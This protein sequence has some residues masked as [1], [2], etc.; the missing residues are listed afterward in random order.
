MRHARR[1]RSGWVPRDARRLAQIVTT[2][3]TADLIARHM[4]GIDFDVAYE[5]AD[6]PQV[7]AAAAALV[8]VDAQAPGEDT[9]GPA[10]FGYRLHALAALVLERLEAD[11][12]LIARARELADIYLAELG[13]HLATEI[14]EGEASGPR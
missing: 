5:I 8:D 1:H 4:P 12:E 9:S 11:R 2:Y 13:R 14:D 6:D 3:D 10:L 7:A